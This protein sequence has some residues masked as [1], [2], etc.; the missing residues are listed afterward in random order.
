VK[1]LCQVPEKSIV[2]V[3]GDGYFST[4]TEAADEIERCA[5]AVPAPGPSLRSSSAVVRVDSELLL[6]LIP[7]TSSQGSRSRVEMKNCQTWLREF[8]LALIDKDIFPSEALVEV[9]QAPRN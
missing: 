6:Y 2:D 3:K 5:L 9:E 8:V 4:D 1:L 7:I